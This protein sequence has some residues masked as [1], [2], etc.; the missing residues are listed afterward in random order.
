[1]AP[2]IVEQEVRQAVRAILTSTRASLS[3]RQAALLE[4]LCSKTLLGESEQIKESTIAIEVFSRTSD[5]DE[6]R[7]S[8][9]RVEAHRLRKKLEKYYATED[10][11]R[12]VQ[13]VLSPGSYVP[14]FVFK[15]DPGSGPRTGTSALLRNLDVPAF[16][17][18]PGTRRLPRIRLTWLLAVV[19]L[20]TLVVGGVAAI[21]FGASASIFRNPRS[22][23][24]ARS[25]GLNPAGEVRIRAG[26]VDHDYLDRFGHTWQTDRYFHGGV[27]EPGPGEFF[28]KPADAGLFSTVRS[29]EFSYDI[30]LK[31]GPYELRLYFAE[32]N[33]ADDNGRD[34]ERPFNVSLNGHPLL[35]NFDVTADSGTTFVD[36]RAFLEFR[37]VL[38]RSV[39]APM[40]SGL[41]TTMEMYGAQIIIL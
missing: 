14:T 29:G 23:V 18:P 19:A 1:M 41:R 28:R 33:L 3:S 32:S 4:Y 24:P 21:R 17:A 39:F 16:P 9:V 22:H 27:A 5:F 31:P 8:V 7:D 11:D 10:Q 26:L 40:N 34:G 30:P 15:G 35:S 2:A 36:V 25:A 37:T 13:I 20:A 12:R 6:Q 38:C